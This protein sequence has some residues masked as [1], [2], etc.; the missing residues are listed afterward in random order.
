M[1][2]NT[3]VTVADTMN[4]EYIH[5]L[6]SQEACGLMRKAEQKHENVKRHSGCL[7]VMR[8][9]STGTLGQGGEISGP[10]RGS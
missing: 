6:Y 8:V 3:P 9:Q 1:L 5:Y 7:N 10:N 2:P 4:T